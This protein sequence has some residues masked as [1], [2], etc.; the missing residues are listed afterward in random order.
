MSK[1]SK[2]ERLE[3]E[4]CV[5][6]MARRTDSYGL[7]TIA[8]LCGIDT[9]EFDADADDMESEDKLFEDVVEAVKT[10]QTKDLQGIVDAL[11]ES[12]LIHQC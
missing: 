2:K 8:N 1:M 11:S 10:M 9:S 6:D 7:Q 5:I 12:G 3:Y 4:D